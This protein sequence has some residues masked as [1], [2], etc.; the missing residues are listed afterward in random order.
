MRNKILI[1]LSIVLGLAMAACGPATTQVP[2]VTPS[3]TAV[4]VIATNPLPSITPQPSDTVTPAVVNTATNAPIPTA[5][6]APTASSTSTSA[7]NYIDDRSTPI[8]L[9]T[10]LFNAINR[11]EYLRAY[12]YW[13]NPASTLGTLAAYTAGYADTASVA[14]VFGTVTGDAG[15]GQMYYTVPVILKGTAI[16]GVQGN[17]AA[18]YVVHLAQPGNFGAPPITPMSIERGMATGISL[19]TSDSTALANAC[20]GSDY[21]ISQPV[22]FGAPTLNIDK[23]N[24]LDNRSGPIETVSSYLNALNS[25]QYVRAYSYWQNAASTLGPYATYANGYANTDTIT[26]TFGTVSSDAGAGQLHYQVP[27]A[28]TV[29]TTSSTTQLFVGCYTLHLAQPAVQGVY[30]FQPMGITAGTFTQ[31]SSS[32]DVSSLLTT[33]CH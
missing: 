31:Y 25:K 10:S 28:M 23:S 21:P 16:N 29:L 6:V 27:I 19:S 11:K 7:A 5:T 13:S 22:S 9:I 18:C 1:S 2:S 4:F 3:P 33:A 32:T 26:A 8:S 17:Y 14:L 20:T 12:S 15:A 24:Y 30:P